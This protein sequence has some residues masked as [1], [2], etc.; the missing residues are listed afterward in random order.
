MAVVRIDVDAMG[1][2]VAS[3]QEAIAVAPRAASKMQANLD[4]VYLSCSRLSTWTYGGS[5]IWL[6]EA[7]LADCK[8]RLAMARRLIGSEPGMRVIEFDD[9]V[10]VHGD[11]DLVIDLLSGYEYGED[12]PQELLD[13]LRRNY[14]NPEFAAYL[15][16]HLQPI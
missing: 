7:R 11:A 9:D 16:N 10:L 6:L 8:R 12:I 2:L 15:A 13:V 14:G 1:A 4:Y 3:L 5:G